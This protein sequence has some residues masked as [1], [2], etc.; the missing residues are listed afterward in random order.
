MRERVSRARPG[1]VGLPSS[2]VRAIAAFG[3]LLTT[4]NSVAAPVVGDDFVQTLTGIDGASFNTGALA[5]DSSDAGG[6]LTV[7]DV[8]PANGGGE[9]SIRGNEVWFTPSLERGTFAFTYTVEDDYDGAQATAIVQVE[10]LN[11]PPQAQF[12]SV[13]TPEGV[14][15][16]FSV[17]ATQPA[18]PEGDFVT[19]EVLSPPSNG[20]LEALLGPNYTYTPAPGFVGTDTFTFEILDEYGGV[21]S[22]EATITVTPSTAPIANDDAATTRSGTG[23]GLEVAFDLAANDG[24]PSETGLYYDLS[25]SPAHGTVIVGPSGTARYTPNAGFVGTDIFEYVAQNSLGETDTAAVTITVL[26]NR[27]PAAADDSA[28]LG[29]W[30]DQVEIRLLDNDSDPDGDVLAYRDIVIVTQPQNGFLEFNCVGACAPPTYVPNRGF[31]GGSD[32]FTYRAVDPLGDESNLATVSITVNGPPVAVDDTAGVLNGQPALIDVLANDT[33]PNGDNLTASIATPPGGGTAQVTTGGILYTPNAGFTGPDSFTYVASD[34]ALQS[35]PATVSIAVAAVPQPP[36]AVDDAATTSVDTP[37]LIDVLANDT[38]PDNVPED[39]SITSVSAPQHG[40]AVI[41][42]RQIEYTPASGFVG[43]DTFDYVV[44]DMVD[45]SDTGTVTVTVV[46]GSVPPTAVIAGGNRA[47]ADSDGVPG[48]SVTVDGSGSFDPD[49]GSILFYEWTVN[50]VLDPEAISATETF[51]LPDGVNTISLRVYDQQE[52]VSAPTSVTITVS[53]NTPPLAVIAGGTRTIDDS[54]QAP[55][56]PGA[57]DGSGSSDANGTSAAYQWSVN[58]QP[59]PGATGANPTLSLGDGPSTVTLVVTDDVGARSAPASVLITVSAAN[60]GPTVEIAGGDRD[61]PDGDDQPGE[62]VPFEGS[63][64]DTGGPVDVATFRWSVN[65]TAVAS[66][67]GQASPTLTLATGANV[68]NLT[69]TDAQG[70]TG[71]DSVT[72]TIG[73][74]NQISDLPDL[75]ENQ[76]STAEATESVCSDLLKTDPT[77]LNQQQRNL[78]ATCDAIFS[79]SGDGEAVGEA[80]DQISGQQVTAQQTA[81]IDFSSTQLLNIGARLQALRMGARG[82]STAGLNL[83]SPEMGVP[84][85]VLASLGKVLLGEGG[86]AGDDEAGLLDSRLGLFINGSLRWG[87]KDAT[88]RESGFDLDSQG[89]TLGADYRFTDTFVAGLALGYASATAD[90]TA[91]RGY[92]DSTGYSGSLYGSWYGDAGYVDTILSYGQIDYDSVRR[93]DLVQLDIR[94]TALGT[95]DGAQWAIGLGGGYDLGKGALRFGPTGSV[96]YVRV[97]VDGFEERTTGTSGL[98]MRFGDQTGESLLLKVGGQIAYQW[99]RKWGILSPQARFDIVRELLNDAQVLRVRYANAGTTLGPGQP[100]DSFEIL[101]DDPDRNYFNWAI[102]MAATFASGFSGFIDYESV[103]G[104]DTLSAEEL[105]FGLR[106][107]ARFR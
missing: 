45:G 48:E 70:A 55:G 81:A 36:T 53:A 40:T 43:T 41:R 71:S 62:F 15:V 84:L 18:D 65:G 27:P 23:S 12:P 37:V 4:V 29:P 91:G 73:E 11:R 3:F 31:A 9:P 35:A 49:G 1:H 30:P 96:S 77:G 60:P 61:I 52:Q 102:G 16:I 95:T 33:D 8:S 38:D 59:V 78:R 68:V 24:D 2:L 32:S 86:A 5:N 46:E 104:Y 69:A 103:A 6:N 74:P 66:A 90:F 22:G 79:A 94:D 42:G 39:L 10:V 28:R 82:F 80:L 21:G 92:Q 100:D 17:I 57:L 89:V 64:T 13:S 99:S 72:V 58:G 107:E 88:E 63:A 87:T 51:D 47:V 19:V 106:Y 93:I 54:D 7:V 101:T 98:A 25:Q 67:D 44:T 50:G 75:T 83:S 26:A 14:A 97:E 105:S 76:K 85:S 20:S 34:G 56:E